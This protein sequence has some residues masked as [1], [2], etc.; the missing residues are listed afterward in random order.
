MAQKYKVMVADDEAA[1]REVLKDLIL[2]VGDEYVV[3]PAA[4]SHE[5]WQI[6]EHVSLDF[7][8]IDVYMP[9]LSGLE[10]LQVI[11][12]KYQDILI[13]VITGQ[14]SYD[15]VLEA[16][17]RGAT[18]FLAKP[19]SLGDLRT[20]LDKLKSAKKQ[21]QA[22]AVAREEK[23][24]L[25]QLTA[26]LH[27]KMEE[28]YVLLE[29]S[30]RL[31]RL[32][33]T[34]E[35]YPMLVEMALN[36]TDCRRA[37]FYLYNQVLGRM[38]LVAQAGGPK[39][40][41]IEPLPAKVVLA[42]LN[43]RPLLLPPTRHLEG[44][45]WLPSSLSLPLSIRG[46][47]LGVLHLEGQPGQDFPKM[48]LAR[49]QLLVDRSLLTLENLALQESMFSNHYDT[50]KALINSLEARDS[51][52]RNH[53]LRVTNIA[54]AFAQ[55]LGLAE[56]LIQSLRLAGALHD[57]GKIGIPDAILLKPDR[58]TAAEME[59]IR[60]HPR[61]GNQI[62]AP[63]NLL[64]REQAI[65]LHHHE[66]WD[67]RG[68]P[69]KLGGEEIPILARIITLAD[70]YDAITTDRPYRARRGKAEAIQEI[71]SHA[72]AQF[73]PE[74]A[75]K[76]IT[77]LR[78]TSTD[79]AELEA[80]DLKND[81]LLSLEQIQFLKKKYSSKILCLNRRRRAEVSQLQSDLSQPA[82]A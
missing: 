36:L 52:S 39:G 8:F 12:E 72:G 48:T 17:R 71:Q 33:T 29:L 4:D 62:V 24:D 11:K 68:Y 50:L 21:Q 82:E 49:L 44:D 31:G 43:H 22:H 53:S 75:G 78:R 69:Q 42:A 23:T 3:Y 40:R 32:K 37:S 25:Q 61:I 18:D 9:G 76:F 73:D 27:R 79:P 70:A 41:L 10:L 19:V 63:L 51:Y 13:V 81:H 65:I 45:V 47:L 14:P 54:V 30:D 28:Q 60:Q 66:R 57:I 56:E 46:E 77:F 67:G 35:F 34:E 55:H 64:P 80:D 74:M 5:A 6:L 2:A 16:L 15:L 58:L 1:V 7:V 59:A 26:E 20:L 38:E